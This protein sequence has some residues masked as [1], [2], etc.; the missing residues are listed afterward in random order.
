[1]EKTIAI[2]LLELRE[3]IALEIEAKIQTFKTYDVGGNAK[4]RGLKIAAAI[5]RGKNK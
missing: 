2:Q 4:N 1:M 5:A 3:Q